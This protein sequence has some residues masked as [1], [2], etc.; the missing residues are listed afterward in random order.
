MKKLFL[1]LLLLAGMSQAQTTVS[2]FLSPKIQLLDNSGVVCSACL[3][4]TFAAGTVTPLSTY[5]ESTGTTLNANPIV[6]DSAGRATVY[7]TS[8]SYKFRLRTAGGT[9]LWTQDNITWS[10]P[11]STFASVTS[12][13]DVTLSQS[14]AATALANQSSNN[15]KVCGNYW[16]GAASATDCWTTQVVLG[17]GANPSTTLTFSHV[18]SSGTASVSWPSMTFSN[19]T[20]SGLMTA[21]SESVTGNASIGGT[22]G[23]TGVTTL[24]DNLS[25]SSGK[26]IK[27]NSDIGISRDAAAVLDIGNGT[28]GDKS[29]T[30]KAA[31]I[32]IGKTDGTLPATI[33]N[34]T[35]GGINV[36]TNGSK[37]WEF[38]N[39][40][41]LASP[42]GSVVQFNGATSGAISIGAPSV[43][44]SNVMTLP[45]ATDTFVGKGTTDTLSN[46]TMQAAGSGN[47]VNLLNFQ[48]PTT[49]KVGNSTDQTIYSYTIPANTVQ[50]N[51]CFEVYASF[52]QTVGSGS[53]TYK[54][55]LGTTTLLSVADSGSSLITST[56]HICANGSQSVENGT[57]FGVDGTT[58]TM[59]NVLTTGAENLANALALKWTFNVANTSSVT[60]DIFI[61][62]LSQ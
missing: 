41:S 25:L 14:T 40:G 43:A 17:S 16:T 11:L 59:N 39:G 1:L 57:I 32:T 4:D 26:V 6:L 21:N 49:A 38:A 44:G 3:L 54:L 19:L 60:P 33:T 8:A 52:Q 61:V 42:L 30:I 9:T 24:S 45:A 50:T 36:T 55:I 53:I 34:D 35:T 28:A 15:L 5:S 46:K 56:A 20:V 37:T 7:L 10:T 2:S 47:S 51:K 62:K 12:T 27:W 13:G 31:N 58:I 29:G 18:G 22:L 48:G 23:V